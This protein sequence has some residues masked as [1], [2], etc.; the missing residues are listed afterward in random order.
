MDKMLGP[1][2]SVIKRFQLVMGLLGKGF[3]NDT[4]GHLSGDHPSS[5]RGVGNE[6]FVFL[7]TNFA[8]NSSTFTFLEIQGHSLQPFFSSDELLCHSS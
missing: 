4:K 8:I 3:T 5:Y 1:N 6:I 2:L 7:S